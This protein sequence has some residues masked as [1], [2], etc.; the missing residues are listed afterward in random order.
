MLDCND[1]L[2]H[3]IKEYDK[4]TRQYTYKSEVIENCSWFNSQ[5]NS[6]SDKQVLSGDVVKVRIPLMD[7]KQIPKIEKGDI[8]IFGVVDISGLTIGEIRNKYPNSMEVSS[9]N[10]NLNSRPY[11][12]HIRCSGS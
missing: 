1:T 11:S 2:T 6:F 9:L 12:R 8:L 7:R 10:Y 3:V 4:Q 5:M